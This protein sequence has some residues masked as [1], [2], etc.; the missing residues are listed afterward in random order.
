MGL[1]MGALKSKIS[2]NA[3]IEFDQLN[4]T[5]K[6]NID[7]PMIEPVIQKRVTGLL[8]YLSLITPIKGDAVNCANW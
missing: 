7:I 6:D 1:V 5:V 2:G 3:A 8:P 4:S